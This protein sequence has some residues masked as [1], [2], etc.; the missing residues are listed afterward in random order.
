M[1][2]ATPSE[3]LVT[4]NPSTDNVGVV[5]YEVSGEYGVS[6][7]SRHTRVK[8]PLYEVSGDLRRARI[9]DT[10]Y[11]VDRLA[12]GKSMSIWITAIDR[13]GNR[14]TPTESTV[15]TSSCPDTTAPTAPSGFR[16][17]ATSQ[18]AVVLAWSASSDGTGVVGYG[19]YEGAAVL[20]ST[21]EPAV[22]LSGLSCGSVYDI[23]VDAYDAAGNRSLRSRVWV[24]TSAC[25]K[26]EPPPPSPSGDTTPPSQPSSLSLS[27][28]TQNVATLTW[29]A[30]SDNV[31]I[32]GYGV[33]RNNVLV[34][35]VSQPGASVSGLT[36]STSDT[37]AVDA[38][39]AAGN[40]STRA[41]VTGTTAA[42]STPPPPPAGDTT[43]PS[44]PT[45][46]V[47][48]S[49][50]R[51]SV[52]LGWAPSSDNVGVTGYGVYRNNALVATA[53]QPNATVSNL[54]CGSAY[55]FEVD[56]YDA[57][58][59]RSSKVS[60][61]GT[62][63][64]CPDTQPPSA[65]SNVAATSRT[66]TSIA[67]SW[68]ASSDN[69]GVVGYGLY[70][71][72]ALVGTAGSTSGIFAGLTCNTNYTL[73]VDAY[74]AAG[75]RSSKTTVMVATTACPDTTPPSAPTGLSVSNVSQN[76]LT[77]TWSTSSDNVGVVGY[78]L[79]QQGSKVGSATANNH[80]FSGL[81]C[82]T[83]YAF[84][85]V[86]F[87]AAGNRS[88][89]AS[90]SASTSACT[91]GS[92]EWTVC[93]FEHQRCSFSGTKEVR[94]GKNWSWT[95]PRQFTDGVSCSN[96][97]FG[98]P[99]PTV[100]KECQT[101]TLAAGSSSP[102]PPPPPSGVQY[103]GSYFTGPLGTRNPLPLKQ[104][105]FLITWLGMPGGAST[106]TQIRE[107][108]IQREADMG[109]K[110][111]GIMTTDWQGDW[112]EDRLRWI[113][114][115]GSIPIVAG[116]HFDKT[117]AQINAGEAD[118][119]IDAYANR[120]RD[121]GFTIMV[122]LHHEFDQSHLA[123]TSVGQEAAFVTA[124]RRIVDRFKA[125]GAT[126]VGFWWCPSEGGDDRASVDR[127]YPG[128]AYVDWV[129]TD[130]Y[131]HAYVGE[132][133]YATP[134]RAG[135]ADFGEIF[136]YQSGGGSA[137]RHDTYGPRKPFVVGETGS[138]WDPNAPRKKGEWF[139]NIP[140]AARNM[141]YLTGI[142]FFDVDATLWEDAR[143]NWIVDHAT[144]VPEV[145]Q[146]YIAMARDPWFNTRG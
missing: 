101:R 26:P 107:R 99:I 90:I 28:S 122:R 35:T 92:T 73:A 131:N 33:Y 37:F 82:E 49:S 45:S 94:Y 76:S 12:C 97:V 3:V 7:E 41:S 14:S 6:G 88:G 15:S 136:D 32:A 87:D 69:V 130:S 21:N 67:L 27:S 56:A 53:S 93:A 129:G 46:L 30:S 70:R 36:C 4:W 137:P 75:N 103:P 91:S 112:A 74:D 81:T 48:S 60:V 127:A 84:G 96:D 63:A 10:T 102:P 128:D 43:P 55:A 71:G 13:A 134:W 126:N 83:S 119:L 50:T 9:K 68:S 140:A 106:W 59:N 34:S 24:E 144:S 44:Q 64:A 40:R 38:Y 20:T 116:L 109:R 117:I 138:V 100:P 78:D 57:A 85:V 132:D 123:Y 143:N 18:D 124:W 42:C 1:I 19:V 89:T 110:Y 108:T 114:D 16:Q 39:D 54:V 23:A 133:R 65:P 120:W 22:T 47:V 80:A 135:W 104:G 62:T 77:L 115:H 98:D 52:T 118:G 8:D 113:Q 125:R 145:Y 79:F 86:A 51:T 5:G 111:D 25:S 95:A 105:A 72:G 29:A 31:G 66:S 17:S 2:S 11:V 139:R 146:G 61:T 121:L 141:E 58:A 142:S